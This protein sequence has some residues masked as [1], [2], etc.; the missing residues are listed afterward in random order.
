MDADT[1]SDPQVQKFMGDHFIT[2]RVNAEKG[3]GIQIRKDYSISGYPTMIFVDSAG[4]E[5]DRIVGYRPPD[6]FLAKVDS[7][8]RNQ[9]TVPALEAALQV[10]P[11]QT[12]LWKRLAAKYEER[13]D[14]SSALGVWN[15]LSDLAG[16]SSDL[17]DFKSTALQARIDHS[18]EPL[19]N[20]IANHPK[21]P[22]LKDAYTSALALYRRMEDSSAE[23]DLYLHYL[24]YME[25]QGLGSPGLWNGFAWRMTE[26]NQHLDV[27]LERIEQAVAAVSGEEAK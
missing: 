16:E 14:Y 18:P 19:V 9:G 5:I 23:G 12:G 13:G 2:T 10:D 8:S 1:F 4:K 7:V 11:N 26:I 15:T 25:Q 27:A 21:N 6:I 20:F 17:I 22:Y 3:E 24:F